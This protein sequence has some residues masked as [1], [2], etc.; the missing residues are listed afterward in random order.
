MLRCAS[1]SGAYFGTLSEPIQWQNTEHLPA[2][3]MQV[4][5]RIPT[6]RLS[7]WQWASFWH[8]SCTSQVCQLCRNLSPWNCFPQTVMLQEFVQVQSKFLSHSWPKVQNGKGEWG[9]RGIR[10]A[11]STWHW[12]LLQPNL[13]LLNWNLSY[14]FEKHTTGFIILLAACQHVSWT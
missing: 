12:F 8:A 6:G 7:S 1:I 11:L 2:C 3:L 14:G 13:A 5:S 4:S 10:G 9:R